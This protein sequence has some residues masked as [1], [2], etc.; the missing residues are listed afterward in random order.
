MPNLD[1]REN[2]FWHL[3]FADAAETPDALKMTR[4]NRVVGHFELDRLPGNAN[5]VN[6]TPEGTTTH[7]TP[8]S[9]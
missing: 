4:L 5:A 6:V 8:S 7:W 2:L 3:D 1:Y 9:I